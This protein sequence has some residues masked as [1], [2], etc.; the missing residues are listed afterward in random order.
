[1]SK[2]GGSLKHATGPMKVQ[3][4]GLV[5]EFRRALAEDQEQMRS[6]PDGSFDCPRCHAVDA[7]LHRPLWMV[8]KYT[9]CFDCYEQD[10]R[11]ARAANPSPTGPAL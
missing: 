9:Y 10:V 7:M 6:A 1:M 8:G 5:L 2:S 11:D 3:H 4:M